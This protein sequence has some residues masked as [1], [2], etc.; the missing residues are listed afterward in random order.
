MSPL[1]CRTQGDRREGL[2]AICALATCRG[3]SKAQHHAFF[4]KATQADRIFD[5]KP[6]RLLLH[7]LLLAGEQGV[8]TLGN[9]ALRWSDCVFKL[10]KKGIVIETID[11]KHGGPFSGTHGR[12]VLRSPI[13]VLDVTRRGTK[14]TQFELPVTISEWQKNTRETVRVRLDVFHDRATVDVRTGITLAER[15]LPAL[16]AGIVQAL[17]TAQ[18]AGLAKEERQE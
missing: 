1:G 3:W 16:A 12:Y 5:L 6:D 10:R 14:L 11:E 8:T 2:L 15:H 9:S 7:E 13:A 18:A 4:I 17:E